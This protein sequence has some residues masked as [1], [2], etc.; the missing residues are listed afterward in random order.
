MMLNHAPQDV[1]DP[2]RG[3]LQEAQDHEEAV[4]APDG[5]NRRACEGDIEHGHELR[6]DHAQDHAKCAASHHAAV[7]EVALEERPQT[8]RQLLR[9]SQTAQ[10]AAKRRP[11]PLQPRIQARVQMLERFR[12]GCK[13]SQ[14]LHPAFY[15]H[16]LAQSAL[17]PCPHMEVKLS[18]VL[19]ELSRR[20]V[21]QAQRHIN[22]ESQQ[23]D[24]E[25]KK[26]PPQE[27][28]QT[29]VTRIDLRPP[30]HRP[31]LAA[32]LLHQLHC[33]QRPPFAVP[34][35][36]RILRNLDRR[37][38]RD[39]NIR[40]DLLPHLRPRFRHRG[41]TDRRHL[42]RRILRPGRKLFPLHAIRSHD[43]P[44]FPEKL[45]L[46]QKYLHLTKS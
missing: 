20:H 33:L 41:G 31:H 21:R 40:K 23:N 25:E 32:Q 19:H 11:L 18:H 9:L 30:A 34:R 35:R 42:M 27:N 26:Q 13:I 2:C 7:A 24:F 8:L 1:C 44:L 39:L 43:I 38:I 16:A 45:L 46:S 6:Q 36:F 5:E 12:Y 4:D 15:L 3:K 29:V 22:E 28:R 10:K 37:H 14:T 17:E